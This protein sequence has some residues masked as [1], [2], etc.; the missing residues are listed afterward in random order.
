R[1][2]NQLVRPEARKALLGGLEAAR[3]EIARLLERVEQEPDR[4]AALRDEIASYGE[5]LSASLLAA[6]LAGAGVAGCYVDSRHCLTTDA[7]HGRATPLLPVTLE[8]TRAAL[9]PLLDNGLVPVL[10]GYIAATVD[11]ITTTLGRGG[12]DYSAAL[13]GAALD[14]REIQIWTDVSGVLT[15]DP[16]VVPAARPIPRLSYAEAAELAYFGARV[17]HPKSIQPA[18]DRGIP[19]RICNSRAPQDPG[20]LVDAEPDVRPGAVKAIAHKTGVT[21]LQVVSSRMLGAYGFLRALFEVFDRHRTEVD[22]VTTSEVS[23]SLTLEHA[24]ALPAIVSELK[25]LGDVSVEPDRAIVCVVGEG[26]R[27]TPGVAARIFS[28][29]QDINVSLISQ[30][31]S[32]VNLTF[33]IE[34]ER[35]REAVQQLHAAFFEREPVPVAADVATGGAAG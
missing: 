3:S 34:E 10:G 31:A 35:V 16:R 7:T 13:G 17:L 26:L 4:R 15:A 29:I 33:V 21:V 1:I 25:S 24:R 19:V 23:V 12:S 14:A 5:R 8:R 18:T 20:T 9:T 11:G 27:T 32:R 2:A 28:T 22:V 6:A 30:G